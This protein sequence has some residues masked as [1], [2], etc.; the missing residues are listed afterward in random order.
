MLYLASR[1]SRIYHEVSGLK[2]N[3]YFEITKLGAINKITGSVVL[4]YTKLM[5]IRTGTR[6][7]VRKKTLHFI[8]YGENIMHRQK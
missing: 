5:Q 7:A 4:E 8:L 3:S 2:I 6:K 1:T